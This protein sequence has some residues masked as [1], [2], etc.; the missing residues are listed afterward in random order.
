MSPVWY[1]HLHTPG[2]ILQWTPLHPAQPGQ[3]QGQ[4]WG[5][6]AGTGLGQPWDA[7][8]AVQSIDAVVS[9]AEEH[10]API[11]TEHRRGAD[12]G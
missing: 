5:T 11:P 4:V 9:G 1:F 12:L 10:G 8:G 7:C 6:R 3:G 2:S